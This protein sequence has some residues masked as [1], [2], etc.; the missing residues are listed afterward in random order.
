MVSHYVDT[1]VSRPLQDVTPLP[2]LLQWLKSKP[3]A[4]FFQCIMELSLSDEEVHEIYDCWLFSLLS[5]S[6]WVLRINNN[7]SFFQTISIR[8]Q[9]IIL[10]FLIHCFNSL[11]W[12]VD[13]YWINNI[14]IVRI[15]ISVTLITIASMQWRSSTKLNQKYTMGPLAATIL[16]MYGLMEHSLQPAR[17]SCMLLF[18]WGGNLENP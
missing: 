4:L 14:I 5:P 16:L 17:I 6:F 13:C 9:S 1:T 18:F 15:R 11:D 3:C 2:K 12:Y 7:V 8:E 10:V